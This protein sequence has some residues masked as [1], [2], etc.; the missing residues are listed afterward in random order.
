MVVSIMGNGLIIK[1]MVRENLF[2]LME[3]N[4][5]V[6]IINSNQILGGY[7]EDKKEGQG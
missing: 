7:V 5:K 4:I 1:C 6:K 2:G 3:R